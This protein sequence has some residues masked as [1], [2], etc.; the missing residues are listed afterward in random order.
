MRRFGKVLW[1]ADGQNCVSDE[2]RSRRYRIKD[3]EQGGEVSVEDVLGRRGIRR[4]FR[5]L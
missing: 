3:L 1:R 4:D 5:T 2:V